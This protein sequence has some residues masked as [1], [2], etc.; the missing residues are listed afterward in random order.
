ME[1]STW[2]YIKEFI[3]STLTIVQFELDQESI[4]S[5]NHYLENDEYEMAF[6]G[7]F[8]EI[9]KLER[10]LKIDLK[11]SKEIAELLKLN[12]ESVFDFDFWKKFES[13]IK[14]GVIG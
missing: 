2:E 9:M 4:D 8:L 10:N 3:Q 14:G 6:E 7:L 1:K 13:Y 12:E 5:V 11:K